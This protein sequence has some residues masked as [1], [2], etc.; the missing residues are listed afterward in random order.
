MAGD[1]AMEHSEEQREHT[2]GV[3]FRLSLRVGAVIFFVVLAIGISAGVEAGNALIRASI[4]LLVIAA[5]GW[6]AE[7]IAATAHRPATDEETAPQTPALPEAGQATQE[8]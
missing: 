2:H 4:A 1:S 6:L 3:L 7:Q 5:C 8:P